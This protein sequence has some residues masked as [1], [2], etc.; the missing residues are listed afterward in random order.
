MILPSKYHPPPPS[1]CLSPRWQV[2]SFPLQVYHPAHHP[3]P[4]RRPHS[5]HLSQA[6]FILTWQVSSPGCHHP[7][8]ITVIPRADI[9]TLIPPASVTTLPPPG[10]YP[11]SVNVMPQ[12]TWIHPPSPPL[13][14]ITLPRQV[15]S[16]SP[17]RCHHPPPPPGVI[18]L[19]PPGVITLPP[20]RCHHP[21]PARCHHPPPPGVIPLPLPGVVCVYVWWRH[22]PFVTANLAAR[23]ATRRWDVHWGE[24]PTLPSLQSRLQQYS[25]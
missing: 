12:A 6:G 25:T 5:I 23:P 21:P 24:R 15:S 22:H 18:T 10:R 8:S 9:F 11:L 19:P 4:S 17:A 13:G 14:V 16:P 7:L 2:S 1:R 20:A 3:P